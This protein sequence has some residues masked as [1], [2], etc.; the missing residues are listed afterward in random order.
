MAKRG[1]PPKYET[2]EQLQAKIDEYFLKGMNMRK[3]VVGP[4]NAKRIEV[5][6]MPTITGLVLYCGFCDRNSFYMLEKLPDFT[7]TIKSARTRIEQN[8][9][10][11]L[12]SGLGAGAIFALKNFGWVDRTE[13]DH[14]VKESLYV[15]YENKSAADIE[16]E[17]SDL[18]KK[19]IEARRGITVPS[20]N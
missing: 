10:E 20:A 8:Y 15:E 6:A 4:P 14:N 17:S 3:V 12:I 11:E 2:P 16:R 13:I 7:N 19:I 18:A 9:E 5:M 1:Q